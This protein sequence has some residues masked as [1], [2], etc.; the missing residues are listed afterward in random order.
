[1]IDMF[2]L[3]EGP[4][5]GQQVSDKASRR[6]KQ[7]IMRKAPNPLPIAHMGWL[8][9]GEGRYTPAGIGSQDQEGC[10]GCQADLLDDVK[11]PCLIQRGVFRST[12]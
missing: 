9:F 10:I 5:K 3:V 1:M 11:G 12:M 7:N 8:Y 6:V 2:P 4:A